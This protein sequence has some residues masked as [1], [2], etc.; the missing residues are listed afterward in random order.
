MENV[1]RIHGW[2]SPSPTRSSTLFLQIYIFSISMS[3][4][5]FAFLFTFLL[6]APRMDG[7]GEAVRHLW[8]SRGGWGGTKPNQGGEGKKKW[9]FPKWWGMPKKQVALWYWKHLNTGKEALCSGQAGQLLP[10]M[11]ISFQTYSSEKLICTQPTLIKS[12]RHPLLFQ[13]SQQKC[14]FFSFP[15]STSLWLKSNTRWRHCEHRPVS[16][17]ALGVKINARWWMFTNMLWF[18]SPPTFNI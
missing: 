14:A 16:K 9:G 18:D 1:E 6:G 3:R 12:R 13:G 15:T 2:E 10:S 17:L 5:K 11:W 7:D 8:G 4:Q